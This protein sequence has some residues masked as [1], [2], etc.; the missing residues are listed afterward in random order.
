MTACMRWW[1]FLL[2]SIV[3]L[4]YRVADFA[5]AHYVAAGAVLGRVFVAAIRA[6]PQIF[7]AVGKARVFLVFVVPLPLVLFRRLGFGNLHARFSRFMLITWRSFCSASS[8]LRAS[9]NVLVMSVAQA[10][11]YLRPL[12]MCQRG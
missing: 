8:R 4:L 9:S 2:V 11:V 3:V 1:M 6:Y 12:K 5:A 10:G 7:A